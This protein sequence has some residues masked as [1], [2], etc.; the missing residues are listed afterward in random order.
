MS[1]PYAPQDPNAANDMLPPPPAPLVA[2]SAQPTTQMPTYTTG[3]IPTVPAQ[4]ANPYAMA[5]PAP[6]LQATSTTAQAGVGFIRALFD[7]SF[8]HYVTLG[9]MK[10][11]YIISLGLIALSWFVSMIAAF[12]ADATAGFIVLLFG[13]IV[14]I[15]VLIG[16]R[17]GL[18]RAV[19]QIRT[20]QN[21]TLIY[22][23][24][25]KNADK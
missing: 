5:Q 13:W 24:M 25:Q 21:T 18:E 1:N 7:F 3:Q 12:S 22:E 23:A 19:A 15:A 17:L 20:A 11:I 6:A 10:F 4:Q 14:A 16:V 8:S 2:P 9:F